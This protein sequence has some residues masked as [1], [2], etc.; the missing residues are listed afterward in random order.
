MVVPDGGRSL[1]IY[2]I[3]S[4]IDIV[5]TDGNAIAISR[6]ACKRMLTRGKNPGSMVILVQISAGDGV[7]NPTAVHL[8]VRIFTEQP[9]MKYWH[10]RA[11]ERRGNPPQGNHQL[12]VVKDKVGRPQ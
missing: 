10:Q 3:I 9:Y 7:K 12:L 6:C 2:T 1:T 11:C 4:D 8:G 5:Q